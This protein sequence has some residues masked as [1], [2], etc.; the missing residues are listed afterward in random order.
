MGYPSGQPVG[1]SDIHTAL[2]DFDGS[3]PSLIIP[4]AGLPLIVRMLLPL[5]HAG[6]EKFVVLGNVT[7]EAR[8]A[9]EKDPRL[10]GRLRETTSL[11]SVLTDDNHMLVVIRGR[12]G[13]DR[14]FIRHLLDRARDGSCFYLAPDGGSSMAS[15]QGVGVIK[16]PPVP[17][18][19][20]S[21]DLRS[22]LEGLRAHGLLHIEERSPQG[23]WT[24]RNT[25][26]ADAWETRLFAKVRA[27]SNAPWFQRSFNRR[28]SNWIIRHLLS[29]SITPN[30]VTAASLVVGLVSAFCFL[31]NS[32]TWS[33]VGW[34]LFQFSYV[35]DCVDGEIA[36]LKMQESPLGAW[37]DS[38]A[39]NIV[40]AAIVFILGIRLLHSTR[41]SLPLALGTAGAVGI[42][43]TGIVVTHYYV[44]DKGLR[45]ADLR[46]GSVGRLR[47]WRLG[48]SLEETANRDPFT[49]ALL[50]GV[51]LNRLDLLLWVVAVGVNVYLML[52]LL[53]KHVGRPAAAA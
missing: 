35:L 38:M 16:M 6:I 47:L 4:I 25:G 15:W 17:D 44:R 22:F 26:D 9:V 33:L 1:T 24:V 32:F 34:I 23:P 43:L 31:P 29:S 36:R 2:V 27:S 18:S 41:G 37:I 42:L 39:D 8:A 46:T 40:Q 5:R 50:A 21:D 13:F 53:L 30:Q 48:A 28:L 12:V 7:D 10:Q 51:V 49:L 45:L 19:L 3:G 11:T 20:P 52:L 14:E